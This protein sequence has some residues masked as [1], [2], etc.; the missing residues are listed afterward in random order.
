LFVDDEPMILQGLRRLLHPMRAEWDLRFVEG[1]AQALD[2]MATQ[3]FDVVVSDMRMPRMNGAEFLNEVMKRYPR[4]IRLILSGHADKELFLSCA[5]CVHQFLAKPCELEALK[6]TL[7]RA[8]D[9]ASSPKGDLLQRLVPRMTHLPCYPELYAEMIEKLQDPEA[10]SEEIGAIIRKDIGMTIKVLNLVNS[11]FFGLQREVASPSEAVS[12]LGIGMIKSLVQALEVVH[13]FEGV[14]L[15]GLFLESLWSH[16]QETA[17]MA[18]AIAAAEQADTQM[19]EEC[20]VAGMLHDAGKLALA[21][22]YGLEYDKAIQLTRQTG[23]PL[24]IAEE[25]VFG[26]NH[27]E[28]GGQLLGLLGL[29]ARVVE[30]VALHH[31]PG[32]HSS[33]VFRPLLAVHVANAWARRCEASAHASAHALLDM[34]YLAQSGVAERLDHWRQACQQKQTLAA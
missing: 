34:D 3:L 22:N 30:A 28:V 4:T 23:T 6:I 33:S 9:L 31:H 5:Y 27:T 25:Q 1:G 16:S 17:G 2:L 12:Y 29:P 32:Q 11:A 24:W 26:V 14:L 21:L 20:Y 19:Q 13:Q 8:S 18:A 7:K 10:S 15:P